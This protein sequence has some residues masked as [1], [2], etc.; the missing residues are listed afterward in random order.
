MQPSR[1]GQTEHQTV[2]L[3]AGLDDDVE[4]QNIRFCV[5]LSRANDPF[6]AQSICN[7]L[8]RNCRLVVASVTKSP[9]QE[10]IMKRRLEVKQQVEQD[11][12]AQSETRERS[13]AAYVISDAKELR[14]LKETRLVLREAEQKMAFLTSSPYQPIELPAESTALTASLTVLAQYRKQKQELVTLRLENEQKRKVLMSQWNLLP[15]EQKQ[16]CSIFFPTLFPPLME[17]FLCETPTQPQ[18][19][20]KAYVRDVIELL[21]S[22]PEE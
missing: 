9:G 15:I 11:R 6:L 21:D 14:K 8:E 10:H 7:I 19:T 1:L 13:F 4:R 20:K 12:I 22:D 3:D 5:R 17:P 18:Q 2:D 16:A